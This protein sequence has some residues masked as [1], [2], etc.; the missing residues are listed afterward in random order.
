MR[1]DKPV[2]KRRLDLAE[3]LRGVVGRPALTVV[4]VR[5]WS[6]KLRS[7]GS[8][9]DRSGRLKSSMLV[10]DLD[11]MVGLTGVPGGVRRKD[12][13]D[14]FDIEV[15]IEVRARCKRVGRRSVNVDGKADVDASVGV[16]L[17]EDGMSSAEPAS[18]LA[19]SSW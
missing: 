17:D 4:V 14:R 18:W 8:A 15:L 7:R 13:W 10:A 3:G 16:E 1:S 19:E 2:G 11:D 6:S 12:M 9:M 5:S